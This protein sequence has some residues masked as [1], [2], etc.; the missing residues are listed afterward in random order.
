MFFY[1]SFPR[2]VD[3]NGVRFLSPNEEES[4]GL[5]IL[6]SIVEHGL[7][8]TPEEFRIPREFNQ[9]ASTI[10]RTLKRPGRRACFTAL[11]ENEL[12]DHSKTFGSFCLAIDAIDARLLGMMPTM[13]VYSATNDSQTKTIDITDGGFGIGLVHRLRDIHALCSSLANFEAKLKKVDDR[14]SYAYCQETLNFFGMQIEDDD[15]NIGAFNDTSTI[16]AKQIIEHLPAKRAPMQDLVMA[17]EMLLGMFQST[18]G[19]TGKDLLYYAQREWRLI[20]MYSPN[21][22]LIHMDLES[23]PNELK[24]TYKQTYGD[25]YADHISIYKKIGASR[26]LIRSR[27]DV[28][29]CSLFESVYLNNAQIQLTRSPNLKE[30]WNSFFDFVQ[31]LIVPKNC[32]EKVMRILERGTGDKFNAISV[33][34]ESQFLIKRV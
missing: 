1:H 27:L 19:H 10:E 11:D 12:N 17:I 18:D 9:P 7:L 22:N 31:H 15:N 24:K 34:S 6:D 25:A 13:Y 4:I 5:D 16:L 26:S 30:G 33:Q 14:F 23:Y 32:I 21:V 3:R 2:T 8:L 28:K 29:K 20:G